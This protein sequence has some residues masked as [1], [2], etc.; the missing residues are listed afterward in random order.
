MTSR[1]CPT[2][3]QSQ[4]FYVPKNQA[5]VK[6]NVRFYAS[7]WPW[8][9]SGSALRAG[10]LALAPIFSGL[11]AGRRARL[12][13]RPARALL[14]S[15]GGATGALAPFC[16]YSHFAESGWKCAAESR[17]MGRSGSRARR[18][19]PS[20][21]PTPLPQRRRPHANQI[22]GRSRLVVRPAARTRVTART[23]H[24]GRAAARR[25]SRCRA[26]ECTGRHAALLLS[27]MPSFLC[28]LFMHQASRAG[29]QDL[30]CFQCN[31]FCLKR[32]Q[33]KQLFV[34]LNTIFLSKRNIGVVGT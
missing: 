31:A 18:D 5:L 33:V 24:R 19:R 26:R 30:V 23:P 6:A 8:V 29:K 28:W 25:R 15:R 12:A 13:W 21:K 2:F 27:S 9:P 10:A 3:L 34:F 17:E 14:H 1:S 16:F 22:K 20:K 32:E 7:C 4:I 11:R